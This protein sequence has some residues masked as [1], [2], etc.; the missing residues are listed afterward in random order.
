MFASL[1]KPSS[2][3]SWK[4]DLVQELIIDRFFNNLTPLFDAIIL[5]DGPDPTATATGLTKNLWCRVRP[6]QSSDSILPDPFTIRGR[7][8]RVKKIINQHPIA[9]IKATVMHSTANSQAPVVGEIWQCRYTTKNKMGIELIKK[10][11]NTSKSFDVTDTEGS[12]TSYDELSWDEI[13]M[14]I[15]SKGYEQNPSAKYINTPGSSITGHKKYVGEGKGQADPLTR[16]RTYLGEHTGWYGKQIYNGNIPPELLIT[17]TYGVAQDWKK[18]V[19]EVTILRDVLPH[20]QEFA[21]AYK[22]EF[23]HDVPLNS[24]YRNYEGQVGIIHAG[25]NGAYPGQSNHGWG[26]A[27]DIQPFNKDPYFPVPNTGTSQNGM[28]AVPDRRVDGEYKY[29][30]VKRWNKGAKGYYTMLTPPD[31]KIG[32]TNWNWYGA[33]FYSD[34][35]Y[36]MNLG[37]GKRFRWHNPADLR[38][39]KG[40]EEPW[41]YNSDKIQDLF[42]AGGISATLPGEDGS[43]KK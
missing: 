26:L 39:G 2:R 27:L 36:W 21:D 5:T 14:A 42:P 35:Y 8:S 16:Y 22:A 29:S 1:D 7:Y 43:I 9:W 24:S 37:A 33:G 40:Y 17:T 12:G 19:K 13:D 4:N 6:L 15:M 23:G 11:R 18:T 38:D 20:W 28:P 34:F 31:D 25:L 3:I 41:H 32:S 30:S 10:Q